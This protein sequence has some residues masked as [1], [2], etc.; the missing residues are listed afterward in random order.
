MTDGARDKEAE[1]PA[2]AVSA[3]KKRP[4]FRSAPAKVIALT[5]G[6]ALVA[7]ACA[8]LYLS[9]SDVEVLSA[10][11]FSVVGAIRPSFPGKYRDMVIGR[12][13]ASGRV[14]VVE[15]SDHY[16]TLKLVHIRPW[17][18]REI[19]L[20]AGR[21]GDI[22]GEMAYDFQR[23]QFVYFDGKGV[24]A[25]SPDGKRREFA[26]PL[27][28]HHIVS[29][30]LPRTDGLYVVTGN[31]GGDY[32]G[33]S[34]LLL[35]WDQSAATE[36]Y[37]AEAGG[38]KA[39][40]VSNGE[41]HVMERVRDDYSNSYLLTIGHD[42]KPSHRRRF[43]ELPSLLTDHDGVLYFY[44]EDQKELC[45]ANMAD[46]GEIHVTPVK[47]EGGLRVYGL[48]ARED[49]AVLRAEDANG[50]IYFVRVDLRSG[51]CQT[52]RWGQRRQE[53]EMLTVD[54][55]PLLIIAE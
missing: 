25:L 23:D 13:E 51:E 28:P 5:L 29:R 15:W 3:Q 39:L 35:G 32:F 37:Y 22:Y 20:N 36:L 48:C 26:V 40:E 44:R 47:I 11:D 8:V 16:S 19:K 7:V 54:G 12:D 53:L 31:T 2:P 55:E 46:A 24:V 27:R 21:V 4:W 10:R 34:I 18:V 38:L 50:N 45:R 43:P 41:V 49:V 9:S 17:E 6:G 1:P 30:I 33:F 52:R 42:R 14:A